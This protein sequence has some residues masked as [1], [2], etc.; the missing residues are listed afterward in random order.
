[1]FIRGEEILSGAQRIHDPELIV[2]QAAIKG[3]PLETINVR[4]FVFYPL[5]FLFVHDGWCISVLRGHISSWCSAAWRRRHW[6]GTC[7]HAVPVSS[8]YPESL[9]VSP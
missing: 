3:I 9:H 1:M 4:A 8:K 5:I 2:K 7:L 6:V